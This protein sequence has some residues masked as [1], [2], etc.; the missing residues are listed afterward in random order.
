MDAD[1]AWF[2]WL[3]ARRAEVAQMPPHRVLDVLFDHCLSRGWSCDDFDAWVIAPNP[4]FGD[5]TPHAAVMDGD[6]ADVWAALA[7]VDAPRD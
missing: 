4:K 3:S 7:M 5:R 1:E 2:V 6:G